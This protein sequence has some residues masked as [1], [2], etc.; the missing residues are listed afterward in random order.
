MHNF[1]SIPPLAGGMPY[2]KVPVS[3]ENGLSWGM[4]MNKQRAVSILLLLGGILVVM[5][6]WNR[7]EN[8]LQE[9]R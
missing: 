3:C 1:Q 4:N 7:P 8:Q 2:S 9:V 5:A 6:T